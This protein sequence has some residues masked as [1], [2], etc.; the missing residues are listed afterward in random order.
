MILQLR[1]EV[2]PEA[3]AWWI[4]AVNGCIWLYRGTIV[5][6]IIEQHG[7]DIAFGL[8]VSVYGLEL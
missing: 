8:R 5:C 3:A 7:L 2:Q 6:M 4:L 1:N